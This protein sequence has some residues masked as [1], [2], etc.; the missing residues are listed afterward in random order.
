MMA[1]ISRKKKPPALLMGTEIS[2]ATMENSMKVSE[3]ILK[4]L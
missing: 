4:L 1:R 3:K 2:A